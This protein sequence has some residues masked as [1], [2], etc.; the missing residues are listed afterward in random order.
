MI[1]RSSQNVADD[2][3]WRRVL[4]R[5]ADPSFLFAVRTTGVFCRPSCGARHP[6]PE[7]VRFF[8]TASAARQAGFRPCRRC[9][10][11]DDA[12]P[13]VARAER[14]AQMA[15]LLESEGEADE[16]ISLEELARR[17]GLSPHHA[18][19]L[20]RQATGLTP[21]QYASAARS[22]R[23]QQSL[24]S[25]ASITEASYAAGYGSSGRLYEE[26]GSRL[27]MT[28]S[29]YRAG[30]AG[31]IIRVASGRCSLGRVLVGATARGICCILLGDRIDEL[32]GELRRR[33]AKA[34]LQAADDG[35]RRLVG[36]V[37]RLVEDPG[38]GLLLP[39]DLR[40]TAFQERVWRALQEIPAGQT[41]TYR[42]LAKQLGAPRAARAVAAACAANPLAVA[43]PCHR[44][45]RS[46]G[47]LA[48]YRWGIVRKRR[49]LER[50][51]S[52][53]K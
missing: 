6:R 44:V 20:F 39:L 13:S 19:R 1:E 32:R 11:E 50:E 23:V 7:N 35:L 25:H 12:E 53:A 43:V 51:A 33:F 22:R 15:R 49:L 37:L 17:V 16:R 4:E 45:V 46:D 3:R 5:R 42:G 18:H 9:R 52:T 41:V 31:E 48:G 27:G 30:G 34:R 8:S 24:A 40:G 21:R 28:P 38:S 2:P 10:P 36:D 14:I 47:E 26:A 29:A